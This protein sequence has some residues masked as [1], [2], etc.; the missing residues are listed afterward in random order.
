MH[1]LSSHCDSDTL[2]LYIANSAPIFLQTSLIYSKLLSLVF[3]KG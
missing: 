2:A 3:V 1:A